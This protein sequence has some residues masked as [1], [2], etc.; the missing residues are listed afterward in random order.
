MCVI[1]C[2]GRF[3]LGN[4]IKNSLRNALEEKPI[5][6]GSGAEALAHLRVRKNAVTPVLIVDTDSISHS[7]KIV[8]EGL[9][10]KGNLKSIA[11]SE[12]GKVPENFTIGIPV[13]LHNGELTGKVMEFL[14]KEEVAEKE[15]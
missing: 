14:K 13:P 7:Q 3:Q 6:V 5:V 8:L 12:K 11:L 4:Q 2:T 1:V 15:K 10:I 9:S